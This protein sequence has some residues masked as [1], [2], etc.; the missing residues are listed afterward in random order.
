MIGKLVRL[1]GLLFVARR[2]L[3]L[4]SERRVTRGSAAG[5]R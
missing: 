1:V 3:Q 4:A 5:R 2:I